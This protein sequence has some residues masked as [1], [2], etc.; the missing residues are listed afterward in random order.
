MVHH[1]HELKLMVF[2]HHFLHVVVDV[3]LTHFDVE[4]FLKIK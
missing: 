3:C 4:K 2:D 1:W